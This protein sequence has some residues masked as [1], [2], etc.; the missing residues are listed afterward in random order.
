VRRTSADVALARRDL[1][2]SPTVSLS[3]GLA[4]QFAWVR[5]RE[6]H[7]EVSA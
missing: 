6:P 2:W 3:E 7:R 4:A 5:S 1:G